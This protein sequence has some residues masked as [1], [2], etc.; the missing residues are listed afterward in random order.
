MGDCERMT[1]VNVSRSIKLLVALGLCAFLF[2][3]LFLFGKFA[4][5]I[6]QL[7]PAITG[8]TKEARNEFKA[9]AICL[10]WVSAGGDPCE[11]ARLFFAGRPCG[12]PPDCS[13]GNLPAPMPCFWIY[14]LITC[15]RPPNPGK[16][17]P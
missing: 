4:A 2:L 16:T 5:G 12:W 15:R 14:R 10:N 9:P 7:L 13:S 6:A 1:F 8:A 3:F 17:R 11:P